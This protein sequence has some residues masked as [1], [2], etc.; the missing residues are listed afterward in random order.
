M[1]RFAR[2]RDPMKEGSSAQMGRSDCRFDHSLPENA[3][4]KES[5]ERTQK[6]REHRKRPVP[7][8]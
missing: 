7:I 1:P 4:V 5:T 3:V 8:F 2:L 6:E